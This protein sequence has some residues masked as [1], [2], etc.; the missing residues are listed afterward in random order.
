MTTYRPFLRSVTAAAA[1]LASIGALA[2][3]SPRPLNF[4]NDIVPILTKASCN[5]GGCHGKASGQN[6][7]KLSLLGFEPGE[8]YEHIVKEARG[9]RVFPAAP[10]Q[11]LLLL[12]AI[13]QLPHGGGKKMDPNS[14]EYKLLTE[15][16]SKG[17]P[18]GKDTDPKIVS[19]EV[20]P[21]Q[22]TMKLKG[23]QQL[24]VLAHYSDGYVKDVTRSALY[25]A[26][27][28][29]MAETTEAGLVKLFDIPGDVAV[30]VRYQGKVTVYRA[31]VPLG[32]PVENL[33]AARNFID[34]LVFAKL[35][36]IGMPPSPICDD[37]TFLRRVTLDLAG[38][39]PTIEETKAFAASKDPKKRDGV[40]DTLLA[41][42]DYADYFANKWA[43]LLRNKREDKRDITANFAFY[44]WVRDGLLENK[45]YDQMA[46][47]LLAATGDVLENPPVAWYKRVKEPQQQ[48]EDVAQLFL[49]TRMQCAQCHHHPFEKWSQQDYYGLAAF[50]SQVGRKPTAIKGEEIIYHKRGVATSTNKRTK[51]PVK[52]T[53][54]GEPP[55]DIPAD[56]DPRLRLADWMSS[57]TNP[58]FAKSLVNRYWK[59][60]FNR[61]LI[62]PEDDMRETNP[63]SNPELLDAMSKFF[64]DSGFD[65]KAVIRAIAQSHTY[66]LSAIP[67]EH[68]AVDRQNFSRY[69]PKRLPAESLFDAVNQITGTRSSF[70]G[71]PAGT[72][73]VALPDNSYNAS[74]Y[75]LTVFGRPEGSSACECERTQEASLAQSLHLLNAQDI[76]AKLT[77]NDGRAAT[78]VK[79]E[80]PEPE[81]LRDLYVAAFSRE[82]RA[83][84]VQLAEKHL[85]K[86]R[87]DPEGKPLDSVAAKRQG[88]EDILW[89]IINT[90]E[91]L[92]NH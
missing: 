84:E 12:K 58:F 92:F 30:M 52:P 53:S 59:H 26:N 87:V 16:I 70:S 60:F 32:A 88:Y 71:L 44:S 80:K 74:S 27:D 31:T 79:E 67:N 3:E 57:K 61:G 19:I 49:G 1:T 21:K 5:S 17:M 75:F 47:E 48:L 77:A 29:S 56:E 51:L 11:S 90:K 62:E 9:R 83:D 45:P 68:N 20:Q 35:K 33:P 72:R 25:E 42:A 81:K 65:L 46:R 89:A 40:I 37:S 6:G 24:K 13:N 69:Y 63:P 64:V 7:F 82:P 66:Q 36:Q 86:P 38:R 41:S 76:Q 23:E 55:L 10:E 43:A 50:F 4:A 15:W 73:A 8:D 18:M 54:L 14:D 85:A 28:K 2:S 34:E 22:N 91:F 39:L 78:L